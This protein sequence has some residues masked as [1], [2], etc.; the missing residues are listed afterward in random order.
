M[1]AESGRVPDITML[2][3]STASAG[4]PVSSCNS[5]RAAAIG[6]S[7]GSSPPLAALNKPSVE[8]VA[9]AKQ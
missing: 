5:R 4:N 2:R 1:P 8:W 9:P 6:D 7:P 3:S